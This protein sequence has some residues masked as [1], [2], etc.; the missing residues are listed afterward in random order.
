MDLGLE[1][2]VALITGGSQ[3]I[4]RATA[5]AM[6][7]H[8]AHVAICA[9]GREQLD[10]AAT[11]ADA[12]GAGDVL[13]VTAD[14]SVPE[15][16]ERFVA[17]S[18]ARFGRID[19]L[20]NN[21]VSFP[22][23]RFTEIPD[24]AWQHHVNVKL[25]GYVRCF[26]A[27]LPHLQRGGWGRVVNIGGVAARQ[28][29]ANGMTAGAVNAAIANFT[30]SVS[31]SVAAEG[32]TV[33]CIHPGSTRTQRHDLVMENAIAEEEGLTRE[34]AEA[35][36]IAGIPIGRLIES[37]DIADAV[38]FFASEASGAITG[39]TIAVDGGAARGVYY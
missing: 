24:E 25:L 39:Q 15:D 21:A 3:G 26:R 5:L 19:V 7:Q 30:K 11:E 34:Q 1:G 23:G 20:V 13:A 18:A 4:G 9:R 35:R 14:M 27:A 16:I 8:G 32:I 6:A 12:L 31:D 33:N 2:R 36:S 29:A 17:E 38:L 10:A 22:V 37:E 28:S